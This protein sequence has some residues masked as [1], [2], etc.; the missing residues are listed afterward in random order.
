MRA[1]T[2]GGRAALLSWAIG[3]A[4]C[5]AGHAAPIATPEVP[6]VTFEKYDVSLGSGM[7]QTVLAGFLLGGPVADLAVVSLDEA[8]ERRLHI[9]AFGEAVTPVGETVSGTWVPA[10]EAA[11]GPEVSFVDVGTINGRDRLITYEPGR[12]SWFDP[13]TTTEHVLV[14]VTSRISA[15]KG[16]IPQVD[17]TRDVNGDG[18]DDLVVPDH[19]GFRVFVQRS[20]GSFAEPLHLGPARSA[21]RADGYRF[22]PWEQGGVHEMDDNRDGRPDLVFW[23]DDHFEVHLQNEDGLFA[24]EARI[25]TTHVA[26]DS[27][28]PAFLAAPDGVRH[29]R[30]D[31]RPPGRMTGRVLHALGDANG[32]GVADLVVFSL[33]VKSMWSA[34]SSY[35]VHFGSPTPEGGTSFGKDVGAAIHS[36]GLPFGVVQHDFDHDGQIDVMYTTIKI[37]VF[38]TL[39]MLVGALMT[40][41]VSLD[42]DL[43]RMESGVP[44]DETRTTR[45]IRTD[46][47]G[48]SGERAAR[49]PSVLIGD[50]NGDRRA[51]LMVGRSRKELHVFLG[52]AGR[53]LIAPRPYAVAVAL[54]EEEYTWLADVDRDGR[55]DVLMHH[56]SA[57]QP[58]RLTILVS[59]G[60]RLDESKEA[61]DD[62]VGDRDGHLGPGLQ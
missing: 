43:Y 30:R 35:Q 31:H 51:D 28:D 21:V 3:G 14:G 11:V 44:L 8:G 57:S 62:G 56:Q 27:E 58:G 4:G 15:Q 6:A 20:D 25:F 24:S 60:G 22:D 55:D 5:V 50:V 46:S 32:D 19:R 17:V 12:L 7:H 37:G 45:R 36:N 59:G 2:K 10:L 48:E 13:E 33:E 61:S 18:R 54:P 29:R 9:Y 40:G 23:N 38:K 41:S 53:S 39:R 34:R 52:V 26:F 49:L 1:I 16:V 47:H 42:L